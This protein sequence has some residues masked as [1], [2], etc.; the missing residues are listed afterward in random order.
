MSK[1]EPVLSKAPEEVLRQ[2]VALARWQ[3]A[4]LATLGQAQ[5]FA[6]RAAAQWCY[7]LMASLAL[8]EG[9][10]AL[11]QGQQ[12]LEKR[13]PTRSARPAIRMLFVT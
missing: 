3:L 4:A 9:W 13:A 7:P 8:V 11:E 1:A 12:T 2:P 10:L 5:V 6:W